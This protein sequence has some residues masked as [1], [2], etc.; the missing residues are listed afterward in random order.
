MPA[1]GPYSPLE[2]V[3]Y[4]ARNGKADRPSY[5]IKCNK[6]NKIDI[7][8]GLE[9]LVLASTEINWKLLECMIC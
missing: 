1:E 5:S 3:P 9:F 8:L 2:R 7:K 6:E 4:T